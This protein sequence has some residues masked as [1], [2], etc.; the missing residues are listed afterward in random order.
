MNNNDPGTLRRAAHRG[1][2]AL[3]WLAFVILFIFIGLA[4]ID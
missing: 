4:I 1:G 2:Q 3:N